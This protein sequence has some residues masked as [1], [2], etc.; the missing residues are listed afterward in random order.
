MAFL[1]LPRALPGL[2]S[3]CSVFMQGCW[4]NV[5]PS[6]GNGSGMGQNEL[7]PANNEGLT[8]SGGQDAG[9]G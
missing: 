9:G 6:I 5:I 8:Q 2:G 3:C 4:R 7:Q 1:G